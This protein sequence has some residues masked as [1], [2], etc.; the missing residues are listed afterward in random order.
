MHDIGGEVAA[1]CQH[2]PRVS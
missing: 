2:L 1:R